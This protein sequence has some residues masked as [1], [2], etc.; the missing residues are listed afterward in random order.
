MYSS[1]AGLPRHCHD[2][3]G[4]EEFELVSVQRKQPLKLRI[5]RLERKCYRIY[6]SSHVKRCLSR[7][8]TKRLFDKKTR[9]KRAFFSLPTNWKDYL[10]NLWTFQQLACFAMLKTLNQSLLILHCKRIES[11][12]YFPDQ[13]AVFSIPKNGL[14]RN[15]EVKI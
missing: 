12:Y 14:F 11:W 15:C 1:W 2:A 9:T 8:T 7:L 10:N 3:V 4:I 13:S 6:L 5:A